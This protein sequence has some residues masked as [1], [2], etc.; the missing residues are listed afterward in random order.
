MQDWLK[1]A[2]KNAGWLIVLGVLEIILGIV[3][4][5]APLA[6]G[7][8]VTTVIGFAMLV[9][10]IARL[11]AAF[12]ADSFGTGALAFLW[13]LLVAATGFYIFTNPGLGL[14]TLTIVL[15]M[16]FFVS[17]LSECIVAFQVKPADGWGWTLTGGIISVLLAIMI[18]R[19]FPLSGLW[20]VGTLVGF[21]L[22][23]A[24]MSTLTIGSA[25][26]KATSTT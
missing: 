24:G 22:I 19:Q 6:G 15:S 21:H 14:A 18:W 13:G 25:A 17:G 5:S 10:G 7:L 1:K 9:G 8:A 4:L 3:V 12:F 2:H 11:F 16:M 23:F 26:R 20:L